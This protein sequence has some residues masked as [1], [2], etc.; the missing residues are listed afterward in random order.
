[1]KRSKHQVAVMGIAILV[2]ALSG[3]AVGAQGADIGEVIKTNCSRCHSTKR[4][5]LALNF[6]KKAAWE[7]TVGRMVSKGAQI[8]P[9]RVAETVDYLAGL[10]PGTGTVC[11]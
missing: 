7:K 5:C 10:K 3:Y 1:M 6:K 9:N 4:I 11:E 2:A 8:P